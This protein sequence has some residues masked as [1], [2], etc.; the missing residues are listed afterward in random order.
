MRYSLHMSMHKKTAI[1]LVGGSMKSAHGAGFLYEF[2]E[3]GVQRPDI[4]IG[5][6]GNAGNVLYFCA[7]QAE[8]MRRIWTELL[9]TRQF[10]SP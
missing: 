7:G 9:S 5:T 8:S 6:S 4:M 1:I 3:L 2:N 10:V